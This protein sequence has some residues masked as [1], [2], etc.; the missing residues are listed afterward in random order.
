MIATA[1]AVNRGGGG[2]GA[3]YGPAA[4]PRIVGAGGSG[5]VAVNDPNGSLIASSVWDIRAVFE[6]QKEGNWY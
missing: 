2:G 6:K 1:A 5:F 4:T 3:A